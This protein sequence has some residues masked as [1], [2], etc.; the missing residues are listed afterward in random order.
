MT[1]LLLIVLIIAIVTFL[2][3]HEL[4]QKEIMID[5]TT[6]KVGYLTFNKLI[7]DEDIKLPEICLPYFMFFPKFYIRIKLGKIVYKELYSTDKYLILAT[8]LL[9]KPQER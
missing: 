2:Y 9:K 5:Y 3:N 6:R 7:F 4:I 8:E 1:I